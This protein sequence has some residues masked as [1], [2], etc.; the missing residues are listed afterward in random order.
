MHKRIT[1]ALAAPL[2]AV[3]CYASTAPASAQTQSAAQEHTQIVQQF[4]GEVGGPLGQMV[5]RLGAR[6]S[7]SAGGRIN[8]DFTLL[9]S[10]VANAFA[11]PSG[12]VYVTR[13]LLA[14]MN[15]E[16]ELAFVL[17]HE[18]GHVAARHSRGRQNTGLL[19]QILTGLAG[20]VTGS[21]IASQLVGAV[22]QQYLLSFSRNQEL[23]SD[24][25]GISY[26]AANGYNPYAGAEI[27]ETLSSYSDN[28]R[29][30]SGRTDEQRS[31]PT[32]N[33]TH[34]ATPQRV[35]QVRRLAQTARRAGTAPSPA[36]YLASIENM[37][38][39][40]DPRQGVIEGNQFLHPDMRLAFTVPQGYGIQNGTNSVTVSG[41]GGQATFSTGAYNGNLQAFL[42]QA[43][44][45]IVGQSQASFTQPQSFTVNGMRA[46][47]TNSRVRTQNS[48]VDL[49][50][51]A[52]EFSPGQAYYFATITPAGRG[53]G[54]FSGMIN[55]LR[56]LSAQEVASVRPRVVDVVTVGRN[57]TIQSLARRMAYSNYQIERFRVLNGLAANETVT[58]GQQVKLVVYAR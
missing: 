17:G 16:D 21:N 27:L 53:L 57:D 9:N 20:A 36:T 49:S 4:G 2:T 41:S 3:I 18:A 12:R 40:D 52:Y 19:T 13:Q 39:D 58:P 30:F 25:L 8:P 44:Q 23:E 22:G 24:R 15:S 48:T 5:D 31:A 7:A 43:A 37:T 34:P 6:I 38:F 26:M 11:T 56:R 28:L 55:S 32:W 46:L 35:A 33:S 29:R 10:P 1:R 54:P 47:G 50:L 51:V 14:L 42:G 45:S